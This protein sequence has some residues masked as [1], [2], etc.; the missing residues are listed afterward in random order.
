MPRP[1]FSKYLSYL[2]AA[3]ASQGWGALLVYDRFRANRL[4]AQ[5]HIQ[6][7]DNSGWLPRINFKKDT[8]NNSWT[9][10][11][12]LV[13][14]KPRLSFVNSTISGSEAL[15][16]MNVI[17]GVLTQLRQGDG[18]GQPEIIGYSVVNPLNGPAVR[19]G[20]T[21]NDIG[22]STID[23]EGR[24][25]LDLSKGFSYTFEA[26]SWGELNN[27]LGEAIKVEFEKWGE[28]DRVWELNVIKVI[29]GG[30]NPVRFS[31]RTHSMKNSKDINTVS[32]EERD[33]GAVLV[34][35]AFDGF[36]VGGWPL[37]DGDMPYLLPS[38]EKIGDDPYTMSIIF[39][40]EVWIRSGFWQMVSNIPGVA[41]ITVEKD[42]HEFYSTLTADVQLHSPGYT[43]HTI[44]SYGGYNFTTYKWP[45]L[46]F[47]GQFR[48]VHTGNVFSIDWTVATDA[49]E[50]V[51]VFNGPNGDYRHEPDFNITIAVKTKLTISMVEEGDQLGEV[52]VKPGTVDVVYEMLAWGGEHSYINN[53]VITA[54]HDYIKPHMKNAVDRLSTKIEELAAAIKPINVLR[55][56]SLLFRSDDVATPR[57]VVTPGDLAMLGDLAPRLTSFAV[58]PLEAKVS[59]APGNTVT[60][61]VQPAVVNEVA[62]SVKGL[63][64]DSGAVGSI[65]QGV[66]TP[67]GIESLTD[68]YKRV[69]VTATANGNSSSAVVTVVADSVAVYPL[70]KV[71]QFSQDQNSRRYVLTG[72]DIDNALKWEMTSGSK[73]TIRE[74]EDGDS[75][76]VIPVDKNVRIYVSP[77][78]SP[79]TGPIASRVHVDGV[80]VSAGPQK[81]TIDVMLPWTTTTGM[82]KTTKQRELA[83]KLALTYYDPDAQE[84]VELSP[85]ET[86]WEVL[87]GTGKLDPATGIYTAGPDEGPYIIVA[88]CENPE[89]SR[90]ATWGFSA[91]PISRFDGYQAFVEHVRINSGQRKD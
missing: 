46:D 71:A 10:C 11:S 21:L 34:G 59:A 87:K 13:L 27:K 32:E 52:V 67:P 17:S 44:R 6:R 68:G 79:G 63:P 38:P 77:P 75:D 76:L 31:V 90:L 5:E 20:I 61:Q 66:Y 18:G 19:M 72:G 22:S 48:I 8:E 47:S 28:A 49:K 40:N 78:R 35:V 43:D 56:N 70:F 82:I 12:D 29:E 45:D 74:V 51:V 9:Q 60:F 36:T 55:L 42:Q 58:E 86:T 41:N 30:L 80:E 81:Q 62:W 88:A 73:G 1:T 64:G 69:I 3:P 53:H 85:A 25:T 37:E 24:V 91:I 83:F 57:K 7:L 23:K 4:L 65:A 39:H 16:S 15:L 54:F 84:D 33:E 50:L 2:G 14:D 89:P 26:D